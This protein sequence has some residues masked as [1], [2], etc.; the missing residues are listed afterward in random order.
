MSQ[1]TRHAAIRDMFRSIESKY[2]S[3]K[4]IERHRGNLPP[5]LTV[6]SLTTDAIAALF[7]HHVCAVRV[8]NFYPVDATQ[9]M[10]ERLKAGV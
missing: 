2:G 6:D 7:S 5:V 4:T 1:L 9:V 3:F 8:P 10:A